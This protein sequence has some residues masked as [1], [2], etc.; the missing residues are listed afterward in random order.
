MPDEVGHRFLLRVY[1]LENID[2]A[3]RIPHQNLLTAGGCLAVASEI[4]AEFSESGRHVGHVCPTPKRVKSYAAARARAVARIFSNAAK[5]SSREPLWITNSNFGASSSS[6][7]AVA[8]RRAIS[9]SSSCPRPRIRA[10][11]CS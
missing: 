3:T 1:A 11:S 7:S 6:A 5:S 9:A 2:A 4:S 8:M 10:T